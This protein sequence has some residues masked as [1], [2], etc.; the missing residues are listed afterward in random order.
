MTYGLYRGGKWVGLPK[1]RSRSTQL[2]MVTAPSGAELWRNDL[3]LVDD[4]A[5]AWA[6]TTLQLAIERAGILACL[7]G[8]WV[9]AVRRLP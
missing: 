2:E 1:R 8:G 6:A 5:Q 3:R 7:P 9:T 4:P